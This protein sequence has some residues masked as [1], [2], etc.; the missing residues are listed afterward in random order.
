M[1]ESIILGLHNAY[2]EKYEQEFEQN[3][4]TFVAESSAVNKYIQELCLFS[5]NPSKTP[6]NQ[7]FE[8]KNRTIYIVSPN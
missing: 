6:D 2:K 1:D 4:K 7:A 8:I 3:T 5:V